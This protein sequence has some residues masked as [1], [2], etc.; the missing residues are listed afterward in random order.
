MKLSVLMSLYNKESAEN[1]HLAMDSLEKQ[2]FRPTELVLVHDGQLT[3]ELYDEVD[4]WRS[5]LKIV[6]VR[7]NSNQGLANALNEGI[8]K[9]SGDLIARMDTDDICHPTRF[10][11]QVNFMFH[12]PDIHVVGTSCREFGASYALDE[13]HLPTTHEE[14]ALF[15]VIRCPFIH[16]SVMFRRDVFDDGKRY[17]TDAPFTEDMGLWC[18]L[19]VSGYKFANINEV[20]LDYRLNEN[21]IERRKGLEKALSEIK[22][23]LYFMYK[24]KRIT[25]KNLA[26]IFARLVFHLLPSSFVKLAYKKA[27]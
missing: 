11:K 18:D 16:P 13:K 26:L 21:T 4:N 14:L 23:R 10:E 8:E 15:S 12:N 6:D 20:L 17:P 27:R 2:T 19:I 25:I 22:V 5:K 1:L 9:C 24:I 3:K 7:L